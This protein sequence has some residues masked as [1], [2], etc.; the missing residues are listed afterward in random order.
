MSFLDTIKAA[1]SNLNDQVSKITNKDFVPGA[2]GAAI[3]V[4]AADG[5]IDASEKDKLAQ[6][7]RMNPTLKL[8]DN[9]I[10]V[11]EINKFIDLFSFDNA[12]GMQEVEKALKK[13]QSKDDLAKTAILLAC[14]I[15]SAD[16]DF[17]EGEKAV[18]RKL[19]GFAGL[20]ARDFNL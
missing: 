15:G 12:M 16:G 10:V 19:A 18:V 13:L 7:V 5:T 8:F 2:V 6:F 11:A 14:A 4:A 9:A 20:S 1:V 17:D 3:A